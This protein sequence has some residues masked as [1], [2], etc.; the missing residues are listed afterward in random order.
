MTSRSL[1]RV[2]EGMGQERGATWSTGRRGGGGAGSRLNQEPWPAAV[3][4][5]SNA[6]P[7]LPS[8]PFIL[9]WS[10]EIFE[11]VTIQ[12]RICARYMYQWAYHFMY[13][14]LSYG[15]VWR[16]ATAVPCRAQV[17]LFTEPFAGRLGAHTGSSPTTR[18]NQKVM[19]GSRIWNGLVWH[20]RSIA[21]S[22]EPYL[23]CMILHAMVWRK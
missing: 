10:L 17:C 23:I 16:A 12:R 7:G 8:Y 1:L 20:L 21:Q 15:A 9:W 11:P 19:T 13:L 18:P 2:P 3:W 22:F 5:G 6:T 14:V 4:D